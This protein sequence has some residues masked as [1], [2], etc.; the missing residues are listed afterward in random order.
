MFTSSE[1]LR[2]HLMSTH[3]SSP[4]TTNNTAVALH[5]Q[6]SKDVPSKTLEWLWPNWLPLGKLVILDGDPGLGK[7]TLL[8]DLAARVSNAALM[9]D[10]SQGISGNVLIL[11]AED[12]AGDTIKPRLL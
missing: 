10:S 6:C 12:D 5:A 2:N 4:T 8:L 7:S 11:S 1:S 3:P 9:P